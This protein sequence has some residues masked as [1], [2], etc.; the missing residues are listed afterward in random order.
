M[1]NSMVAYQQVSK[2][3]SW[4]VRNALRVWF[5]WGLLCRWLAFGFYRLTGVIGFVGSLGIVVR[6]ADGSIEDYGTVGYRVVT[7]AGI[8]AVIA[9]FASDTNA[10]DALDYH[11]IGTGT[12]AEAVGDTALQAECTT[13]LNPDS[14]RAVGTP[15]IPS[16]LVYR[17]VATFTFDG[18][19]ALTE[20]GILNA[21]STGTLWDRTVYAAINVASGDQATFT[22]EATGAAGG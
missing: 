7:T 10:I 17:S 14:T 1:I 9:Q 6:R 20:H 21:A 15:S 8:A 4:R 2:V 22:Y 3:W 5:W 11:A 16:S 12:S 13:V 19:A 18:S